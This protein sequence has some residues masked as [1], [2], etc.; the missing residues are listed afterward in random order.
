MVM[1]PSLPTFTLPSSA[2][3]ICEGVE[4]ALIDYSVVETADK[5]NGKKYKQVF[6]KNMSVKGTPKVYASVWFPAVADLCSRSP[7]T[8]RKR[9]TPGSPS[10]RT[11]SASA[12]RRSMTTPTPCSPSEYM[13]WQERSRM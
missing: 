1:E 6:S 13:I 2:R 9:S 4:M 10:P 11:S 8:R 7:R 5:V 12:W 3:V